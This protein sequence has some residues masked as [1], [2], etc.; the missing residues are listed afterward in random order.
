MTVKEAA[1]SITPEPGQ[2]LE[3]DHIFTVKNIDII[4]FD[5]RME[6]GMAFFQVLATA[7]NIPSQKNA[8]DGT[9][10]DTAPGSGGGRTRLSPTNNPRNN[11]P[12]FLGSSVADRIIRNVKK[13]VDTLGFQAM[14]NRHASIENVQSKIT[15]HGNPQLLNEM[16]I[17]P[18]EISAGQIEKPKANQTVN[19]KWLSAPTLLKINI[20]TPVDPNNPDRG[21][22][23]FWYEGFY[24]LYAISNTF[25]NGQF[26]Q[27]LDM[28]TVPVVDETSTLTEKKTKDDGIQTSTLLTNQA[29]DYITRGATSSAEALQQLD[30]ALQSAGLPT[31]TNED[32]TESNV[33]Q[34]TEIR[35]AFKKGREA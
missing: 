35:N 2:Y 23:P 22:A 6:L 19:P 30:Q 15:I 27:V 26:T 20:R 7:E 13:P 5:I 33:A 25:D 17:L 8:T 32:I 29:I 1:N 14:L 18:S 28:F 4:D 10:Q 31:A 9:T 12:L 11:T 34:L 24:S 21:Y 16:S 3:L